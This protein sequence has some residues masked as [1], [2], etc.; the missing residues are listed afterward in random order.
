MPYMMT[1]ENKQKKSD[2]VILAD[3]SEN[4]ELLLKLQKE[5]SKEYN[6]KAPSVQFA[7]ILELAKERLEELKCE[8]D[9]LGNSKQN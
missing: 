3:Q 7:K 9:D 4:E 6:I 2:V 8:D 1:L 5:I